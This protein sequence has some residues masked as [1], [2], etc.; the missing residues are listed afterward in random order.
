MKERYESY[1]DS[2]IHWIGQVPQGW[3]VRRIAYAY[4]ENTKQNT[5]L[6]KTE[7][8]QF[9]YGM[10]IKKSRKYDESVDSEV[11]SRYTI[12]LPNDIV[13]NGLNL[14]Y[15]FVSQ[16]VA[17]AKT[18]GII[19]SA[20]VCITPRTNIH[21]PYFCYLFKAMDAMKLFHGMGT[22][23]RLTLSYDELKK[24]PI[25]LPTLPEQ[26]AIAGYLDA[27]CAAID[28]YVASLEREAGLARELKQALIARAVTRGLDPNAPMRDSGIPWIGQ[29]PAGWE[30]VRTKA[31][32]K[33]VKRIVGNDV[34]KYERLALTMKGVIKRSKDD[35]EGLQPEKFE[36]YQILKENEL[37]FKLIDL[38][39]VRTS[40][41]GISP[42][43]GLVSP[44]YIILTNDIPDNRY[45]YYWFM[46]MYH[47]NVFNYLGS[48]GV[49][50]ALN[51]SDLLNIKIPLPPLPEQ[52]SIAAYLDERCRNIDEYTASL[53]REASLARELKQREIADAVTGK[54][55]VFNQ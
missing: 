27:R 32:F 49:R 28:A 2:G 19:T 41:V 35:G 44:V 4:A 11:Y 55:R 17:I 36:T 18:E 47:R 53:E 50:S 13:I 29:V 7:A 23:I 16:R 14:N 51:A 1:K 52:C 22:G 43:I 31:L 26:R 40:R 8:Y 5:T 48:N 42:Y 37:V 34:D 12:F 9:N 25:P 3:D 10:L 6:E 20:Y 24:Q 30:V 54:V 39:N 45:F 21:S 15:D 38:Q 33:S 46:S